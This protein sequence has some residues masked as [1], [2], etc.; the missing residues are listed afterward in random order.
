MGTGEVF[1]EK[2]ESY[3]ISLSPKPLE[4]MDA[5]DLRWWA[6]NMAISRQCSECKGSCKNKK[7]GYCK[8]CI[9]RGKIHVLIIDPRDMGKIGHLYKKEC[10]MAIPCRGYHD[11]RRISQVEHFL[12]NTNHIP[13]ENRKNV[14]KAIDT[15]EKIVEK[16]VGV[17]YEKYRYNY[18]FRDQTRR[19][20]TGKVPTAPV[21]SVLTNSLTEDTMTPSEIVLH[22][23]RLQRNRRPGNVSMLG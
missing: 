5:I 8:K 11:L 13:W 2:R 9:G 19:R 12:N 3:T 20:L 21:R 4:K 1:T 18:K 22:R 23:R 7:G 10:N 16:I 17:T 14:Q 6:K 15:Y